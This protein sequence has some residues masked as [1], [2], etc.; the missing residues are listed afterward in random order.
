[1]ETDLCALFPEDEWG[2]I[3]VRLI[4]HGRRVCIA[5]RPR[6]EDCM[7]AE[8]CPSAGLGSVAVSSTRA[9]G[10]PRAKTPKKSAVAVTPR[11][12]VR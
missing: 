2:A 3:S 8:V 4:L 7:L 10:R 6:C 1:V 5:R 12:E 9:T 11:P